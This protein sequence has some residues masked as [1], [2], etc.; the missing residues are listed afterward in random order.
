MNDAFATLD[1]DKIN[2][3][4]LFIFYFSIFL[5]APPFWLPFSVSVRLI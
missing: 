1:S 5:V 2:C 4:I 3:N